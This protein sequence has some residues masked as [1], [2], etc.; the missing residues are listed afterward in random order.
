LW[1]G[2]SAWEDQ[3]SPLVVIKGDVHVSAWYPW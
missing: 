3:R 1:Q 2:A